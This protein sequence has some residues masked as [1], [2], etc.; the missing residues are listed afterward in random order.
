M[1]EHIIS[2]FDY[3]NFYTSETYEQSLSIFLQIK[4][5]KIERG[6]Y[7]SRLDDYE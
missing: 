5:N 1:I 2:Y 4:T 3:I 7:H 6:I